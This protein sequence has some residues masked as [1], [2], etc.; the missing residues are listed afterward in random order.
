MATEVQRR[1]AGVD[2]GH[3]IYVEWKLAF[4]TPA[5][6]APPPEGMEWLKKYVD[7]PDVRHYQAQLPF[8]VEWWGV[9]GTPLEKAMT[10][11][12]S[13]QEGMDQS[14]AAS[15]RNQAKQ[16]EEMRNRGWI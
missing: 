10:G 3:L 16:I 2:R 4:D 12:I 9:W 11:D 13:V 6:V 1:V 7:R 5:A 14:K 8:S 15:E